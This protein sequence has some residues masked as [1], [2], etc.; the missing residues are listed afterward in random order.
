[1]GGEVRQ[2]NRTECRQLLLKKL[3]VLEM[4]G[5]WWFVTYVQTA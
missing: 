2:S 4:G 1:M 3:G 5:W